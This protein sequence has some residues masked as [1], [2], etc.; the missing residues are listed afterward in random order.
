[1]SKTPKQGEK[2]LP[3]DP[4]ATQVTDPLDSDQHFHDPDPLH[5][6]AP[7]DAPPV[8]LTAEEATAKATEAKAAAAAAQALATQLQAEADAAVAEAAAVPPPDF[9]P[10]DPTMLL[11]D[12]RI[13]ACQ[14]GQGQGPRDFRVLVGS[15]YYEHVANH[16]SGRWIYRPVN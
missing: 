11:E 5:D 3:D 2:V 1:M 7:T 12:G 13:I 15:Q 10:E 14:K 6:P 16:A 8:P 9:D 4:F